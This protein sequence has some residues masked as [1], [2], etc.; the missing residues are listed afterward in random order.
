VRY[1]TVAD[2][3]KNQ[4]TRQ[5]IAVYVNRV[6]QDGDFSQLKIGVA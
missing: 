1:A 6:Y 2:T 5:P 3:S 4:I